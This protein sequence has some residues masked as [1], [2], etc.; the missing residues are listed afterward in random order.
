M[1]RWWLLV[2]LLN[3]GCSKEKDSGN[4]WASR[5]NIIILMVDDVRIPLL[6]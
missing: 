2:A 6:K 4:K 3:A 5:P 1:W